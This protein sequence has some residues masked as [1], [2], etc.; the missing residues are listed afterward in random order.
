M[1]HLF[2]STII[3]LILIPLYYCI[4]QESESRNIQTDPPPRDKDQWIAAIK[5]KNINKM[6]FYPLQRVFFYSNLR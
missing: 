6:S 2:T 5:S 1:K 4:A 3:A